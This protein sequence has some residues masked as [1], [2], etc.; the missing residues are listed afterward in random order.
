MGR[1]SILYSSIEFIDY[2]L[3]RDSVE[4]AGER[5][6]SITTK[7]SSNES[8]KSVILNKSVFTRDFLKRSQNT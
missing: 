3:S 4:L 2:I 7:E 1:E 5:D 8:L 6:R